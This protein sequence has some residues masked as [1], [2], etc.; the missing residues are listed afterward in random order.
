[1]IVWITYTSCI[2]RLALIILTYSSLLNITYGRERHVLL[3]TFCSL[4]LYVV[5]M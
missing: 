4:F 3:W 2:I 5:L 1:M